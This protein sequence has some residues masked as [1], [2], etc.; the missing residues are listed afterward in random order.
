MNVQLPRELGGVE[1][2]ALYVDTHGDFSIDRITD[3]ARHL[4]TSV[5]KKLEKDQAAT[6]KKFKED[7]ALDRILAKVK[8]VRILD[9]GMQQCFI[10]QL[11]DRLEQM[12]KVK[13]IIFDTFAE[14]F[15][16]TDLG[17]NERKR[18][19]STVLMTLMDL[20]QRHQLAI[21]LVNNMKLSKKD[22]LSEV[23][24]GQAQ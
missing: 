8:Y 4:R 15:R 23:N 9:E 2:E 19:I 13:L 16:L 11:E 10:T 22:F 3:L 18:L 14:H 21:I 6:L 12:P 7:F 5:L 1:G 20:A 17:Y 24:P